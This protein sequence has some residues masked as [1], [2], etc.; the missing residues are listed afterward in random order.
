ML[1]EL[2]KQVKRSV[3]SSC[4]THLHE[5]ACRKPKQTLMSD[6][7]IARKNDAYR[8]NY[9]QWWNKEMSTLW[10]H[11]RRLFSGH[12]VRGKPAQKDPTLSIT[13]D[14]ACRAEHYTAIR[15]GAQTVSLGSFFSY[16]CNN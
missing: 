5:F 9:L 16:P 12:Y 10:A 13:S 14:P 2:C 15:E 3:N 8:K 1:V 4:K 11:V 7:L 6:S